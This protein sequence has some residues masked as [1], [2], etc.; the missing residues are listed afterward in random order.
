M[1]KKTISSEAAQDLRYTKFS[2][3]EKYNERVC[4]ALEHDIDLS[5][6]CWMEPIQLSNNYNLHLLDTPTSIRLP[7]IAGC[8]YNS[9]VLGNR[10]VRLVAS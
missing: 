1:E 3:R 6:N 10:R 2:F 7:G 8:I 9:F 4:Y 5:A